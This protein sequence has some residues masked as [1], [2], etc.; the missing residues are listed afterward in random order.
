MFYFSLS[1][2]IFSTLIIYYFL[3]IILLLEHA[4]F[5]FGVPCHGKSQQK[6]SQWMAWKPSRISQQMSAP[7]LYL[8]G[9]WKKHHVH[10]SYKSHVR[11]HNP[12]QKD[13]SP[14]P[15]LNK[16][17]SSVRSLSQRTCSCHMPEAE[18]TVTRA[19]LSFGTNPTWLAGCGRS[20]R[21]LRMILGSWCGCRVDANPRWD[22]E[23]F[24]PNQMHSS[25]L[26]WWI[27][28]SCHGYLLWMVPRRCGFGL[29]MDLLIF[30]S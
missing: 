5:L 30:G 3:K 10:A 12:T 26:W 13:T 9:N 8:N 15:R 18:L 16:C 4:M 27:E 23:G 28:T 1:N 17:T 24:R 25:G 21:I 2:L 14:G 6:C 11:P 19:D 20:F 22:R 29:K 7:A